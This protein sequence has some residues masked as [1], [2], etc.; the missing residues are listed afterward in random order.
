MNHPHEPRPGA[1]R[2]NEPATP[3]AALRNLDAMAHCAGL[4]DIRA[5]DEHLVEQVTGAFQQ[6]ISRLSAPT[7]S[8]PSTDDP[9]SLPPGTWLTNGDAFAL[10]WLTHPEQDYDEQRPWVILGPWGVDETCVPHDTVRGWQ[11]VPGTPILRD[12]ADG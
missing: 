4:V 5:D 12:L 3:L 7:G 8:Q 1:A 2:P 6:A 9:A 11:I 10:R